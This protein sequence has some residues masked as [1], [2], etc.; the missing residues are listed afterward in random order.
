MSSVSVL[1]T[2]TGKYYKFNLHE[3]SAER[4]ERVFIGPI[5]LSLISCIDFS[6]LILSAYA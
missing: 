4:L 1:I 2:S 3:S 5:R 6:F